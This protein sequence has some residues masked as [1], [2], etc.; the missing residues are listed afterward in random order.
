MEKQQKNVP[1]VDIVFTTLVFLHIYLSSVN[2]CVTGKTIAKGYE[3]YKDLPAHE[4]SECVHTNPESVGSNIDCK[5]Y[6]PEGT[7][8]C[9]K[10]AL[11][12]K[13]INGNEQFFMNCT[14]S[15]ALDVHF[16]GV[17]VHCYV[18]MGKK[19]FA[20]FFQI[21]S[22][23]DCILKLMDILVDK[24]WAG[25]WLFVALTDCFSILLTFCRIGLNY[26][27]RSF[28]TTNL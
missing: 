8:S 4:L 1:I 24:I 23:K 10:E 11:I 28:F 9:D 26:I 18:S 2:V 5:L 15:F 19:C 17:Q 3:T 14:N 12:L 22:N 20:K 6:A 21:L 7:W 16:N 27:V 13:K 25:L